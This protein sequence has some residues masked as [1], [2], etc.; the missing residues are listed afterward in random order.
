MTYTEV[1][2]MR[3]QAGVVDWVKGLYPVKAFT[4]WRKWITWPA[5]VGGYYLMKNFGQS[6]DASQFV[7]DW[8]KQQKQQ[9][10]N[11]IDNIYKQTAK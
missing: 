9:Q 3:K 4:G 7:K 10:V 1:C 5:L 8:Y 6:R 11:N 2:R